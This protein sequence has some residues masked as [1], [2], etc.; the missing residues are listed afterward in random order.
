M[1]CNILSTNYVGTQQGNWDLIKM[2]I[3]GFETLRKTSSYFVLI[4]PIIFR[5]S[6]VWYQS[7]C[8]LSLR[9]QLYLTCKLKLFV[10]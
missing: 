5:K 2:D 7:I 6:F 9:T 8:K 3:S 10:L 4:I 1:D